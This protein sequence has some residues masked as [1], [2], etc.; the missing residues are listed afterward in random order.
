MEM[1]MRPAVTLSVEAQ[2]EIARKCKSKHDAVV[3][4]FMA[5]GLEPKEVYM[6]LKKSQ[7]WF[8]KLTG[9][10]AYFDPTNDLEQR[11]ME[12]CG[13]EIPLR[14]DAWKSGYELKPLISGLEA[15]LA[16]EREKR[17]E[18]ERRARYLEELVMGRRR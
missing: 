4:C 15:E 2:E 7:T 14:Y 16:A 12:V 3:K 6:P 13:N 11:Y 1:L 8:S 9:G 17:L 10:D 18:A 5:S